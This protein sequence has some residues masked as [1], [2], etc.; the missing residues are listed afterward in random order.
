M[1]AATLH[2][3]MLAGEFGLY[4]LLGF[5]LVGRCGWAPEQAVGLALILV[6]AGRTFIIGVTFAFSRAYAA[7]VPPGCRRTRWRRAAA[8]RTSC[9]A[10]ARRS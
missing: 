4:L 5:L 6:V 8:A 7:P 9:C 2:R 1:A 10:R 3:L